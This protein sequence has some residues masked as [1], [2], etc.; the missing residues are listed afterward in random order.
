MMTGKTTRYF[1]VQTEPH[2]MG[3]RLRELGPDNQTLRS[4]SGYY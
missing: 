3:T 2:M 1:I 4:R